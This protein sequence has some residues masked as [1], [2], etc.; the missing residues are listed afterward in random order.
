MKFSDKKINHDEAMKL[1]RQDEFVENELTQIQAGILTSSVL[2]P[3]STAY[4]TSSIFTIA[5]EVSEKVLIQALQ[6]FIDEHSIM[7]CSFVRNTLNRYRYIVNNNV[8]IALEKKNVKDILALRESAGLELKNKIDLEK[9]Q[10]FKFVLYDLENGERYLQT[11]IHHIIFDDRSAQVFLSEINRNIK[12]Y[13]NGDIISEPDNDN[14]FREYAYEENRYLKSPK[15]DKDKNYWLSQLRSDLPE[16]RMNGKKMENGSTDIDGTCYYTELPFNLTEKLK[17]KEFGTKVSVYTK[18]LTAYMLLLAEYGS[19]NMISVGTAVTNRTVKN[20]DSVGCFINMAVVREMIA[21]EKSI[22]DLILNVN[23]KTIDALEHERYP[24]VLL[25]RE[26]SKRSKK[27]ISQLFNAAMYYNEWKSSEEKYLNVYEMEEIHQSGEYDLV[28]EI[29]K[30]GNRFE[31][32]FKYDRNKF[33]ASFIKEL[34]DKYRYI[35]ECMVN[36]PE[37]M[38]GSILRGVIK[39]KNEDLSFVEMFRM[40]TK[41]APESIAVS[42]DGNDFTYREIYT[43]SLRL[44]KYLRMK[45]VND[46]TYVGIMLR[47]SEKLLISLIAVQMAGGAYIPMDPLYPKERIR[48]MADAAKLEYII[49]DNDRISDIC[50]I[51]NMILYEEAEKYIRSDLTMTNIDIHEAHTGRVAYVIFTSGSTGNPKGIVIPHSA[52]SNFLIS[53]AELIGVTEKDVIL[54][55]TTI[56]FDIAVLEMYLML[57]VGGKVEIVPDSIVRNGILL[58]D[59]FMSSNFTIMQATPATWQMLL[60]AGWNEKKHIKILCGGEKMT[61]ELADEILKYSDE[62]WNMYGPTETTVWSMVSPVHSS[63]QIILGLPIRKTSIYILDGL[64]ETDEG[65][66]CIG[67]AGLAEGYL[68]NEEATKRQFIYYEKAGERIYRTGDIVKRMPDGNIVYVGRADF[69]IKIKGYRVELGEIEKQL[70][71]IK[72]IKEAVVVQKAKSKR[73]K[74]YLISEGNIR[75]DISTITDRLKNCLAEYMIPSSFEYVEAYPLT[76]NNKV[77]R[78]AMAAEEYVPEESSIVVSAQESVDTAPD[79]DT[80]SAQVRKELRRLTAKIQHLKEEDIKDDVY[81]GEYEYESISFTALCAE[82]NKVYSIKLDPSIFYSYQTIGELSAHIVRD[83]LDFSEFTTDRPVAERQIDVSEK[84]TLSDPRTESSVSHD[85]KDVAVIG[86]GGILPGADDPEQFWDILINEKDMITEI[87]ISRWDWREYY[88]RSE[89]DPNRISSKWGG[90]INDPDKF[91]AEFFKISPVEAELMDPQQ[92]I[93]LQLVWETFENAGYNP[94]NLS[95]H[96]VGVFIGATSTDY[97]EISLREAA[98]RPH[99]ITGIAN[100]IISNR[101]SYIYNFMGPSETI[102]TACSS[103]LVSICR[104]VDAINNGECEYAIAGGVNLL[105][106]PFTYIA[107]GNASM[108]SKDGRCKAFDE[109]ANG[110]VRG[111]GAVTLLL[112]PLQKAIEDRDY[113]YAVVKGTAVNH[114]GRSNSLTAPNSNAQSEVIK[115]AHHK[116]N[117]DPSTIGYIET[118]GTG[119]ALGDPIEINGLINAFRDLYKE[120]NINE[121]SHKCKL[122]SVKTNIGHLEAASG[123]ASMLKMVMAINHKTVPANIHFHKLNPYIHLENTPFEIQSTKTLWNNQVFCGKTIPLRGGVSSFGFGGT[124]AHVIL[125]EYLANDRND[126]PVSNNKF[127]IPLSAQYADGLRIY[128]DRL[129]AYIDKFPAEQDTKSLLNRMAYTLQTG[130]EAMRFRKAFV[131]GSLYELKQ[132]LKKYLNEYAPSNISSEHIAEESVFDTSDINFI[133]ER[134]WKNGDLEKITKI[135]ELCMPVEWEKFY[136]DRIEKLPMPT[137]PFRKESFYLNMFSNNKL[138]HDNKPHPLIDEPYFAESMKKGVAFRKSLSY[139]DA[140]IGEHIVKDNYVM[141]GTSYLEMALEG[142]GIIQTPGSVKISGVSWQQQLIFNQESQKDVILKLE[143]NDGKYEYQ[144]VTGNIQPVIHGSGYIEIAKET[145]VGEYIDINGILKRC[146]RKTEKKSFYDRIMQDADIH[147]GSYF[148]GVEEV[149]ANDTEAIGVLGFSERVTREQKFYY[150]H[151]VILDCALQVMGYLIGNEKESDKT[152]IPFSSERIIINGPVSKEKYIVYAK[153]VVDGMHDIYLLDEDGRIDVYIEKLFSREVEDK[154]FLFVPRLKIMQADTSVQS[155]TDRRCAMVYNEDTVDICNNIAER[156]DSLAVMINVDHID[157]IND[158]IIKNKI[159]SIYYISSLTADDKNDLIGTVKN[160]IIGFFRMIKQLQKTGYTL[161][162]CVLTHNIFPWKEQYVLPFHASLYGFCKSAAKEIPQISFRLYDMDDISAGY[163]ERH[164]DRIASHT[165]KSEYVIIREGYWY[166]KK[167]YRY[168]FNKDI[169]NSPAIKQNG[170]YL[171][172]GMGGI[173]KEIG[174]HLSQ[175]Y[176]AT[177]IYVSRGP[178]TVDKEKVMELIRSYGGHAFYYQADLTDA[179]AVKLTID[180]LENDGH[181]INGVIFGTMVLNDMSISAMDEHLLMSV[182]KPKEE[183]ILY[184]WEQ[185]DKTA[186]D[187]ALVMSSVSGIVGNA[188]QSNYSAACAVADSL[189]YAM[190]RGSNVDV[191]VIDWSYWGSVGAVSSDEYNK[192]LKARGLY[193]IHVKEGIRVIEKCLSGGE[194]HISMCK[195]SDDVLEEMGF[196]LDKKIISYCEDIPSLVNEIQ[197]FNS[198]DEENYRIDEG[199]KAIDSYCIRLVLDYFQKNGIF[200]APYETVTFEDTK[201]RLA[202]IDKYVK[203]LRAFLAILIRGG[204]V[205]LINNE[206][207]STDKVTK[208]ST[209]DVIESSYPELSAYSRLTKVCAA[210]FTEILSGKIK[211]TDVMFPGGSKELVSGIYKGNVEADYYNSFVSDWIE[212]YI[213][214]RI[215]MDNNC[216]IRLLEIGAGTG[217]TSLGVFKKISKFSRN[218][219]YI[220]TDISSSFTYYGERTYGEEYPFTEYSVLNIEKDSREYGFDG[221]SFDIVLA[222]NVLH[223]T[224]SIDNTMNNIKLLLRKNGVVLIN[225]LTDFKVFSTVTF[226]LTEGWWL[227]S[228]ELRIPHS[229]LLSVDMWKHRLH[230]C[231]YNNIIVMPGKYERKDAVQHVIVAESDGCFIS[232][233]IRPSA[234]VQKMKPRAADKKVIKAET[235]TNNIRNKKNAPRSMSESSLKELTICWIKEEF[236]SILKTDTGKMNNNSNIGDL[237]IDSLLIIEIHKMWNKVFPQFPSTVLFEYTTINKIADFLIARYESV[238][239]ELIMPEEDDNNEKYEAITETEVF[240]EQVQNDRTLYENETDIDTESRSQESYSS[241]DIAVIGIAGRYPKA[242]NIH[243][244]WKNLKDGV[245]CIRTIPEDRWKWEDYYDPDNANPG[246][247]Y[248]KWGGFIDDVI[249]F[250]A[251]FFGFTEEQA[252]ELD[253]QERILLETTW[254]AL[255]DA[256]YPGRTLS[257]SGKN[258]GV[259]IGTMYEGYNLL[260]VKAWENGIRTEAQAAHWMLPNRIS[261]Y[262]GFTG[263]SVSF[264]TACASSMTALNYACKS[265]KNGDCNMAVVGGINLILHPRQ[266]VRLAHLDNLS[267]TGATMPFSQNANGFVEG[268]GAGT[269]LLKPLKDAVRDNDYIYGVI[270]ATNI[271]CNGGDNNFGNPNIIKQAELIEKSLKQAGFKPEDIN[272]V[273]AHAVGTVLGDSV[274]L[275]ALNKVFSKKRNKA[276]RCPVGTVKSNI[277]HTEA[278]SGIAALTKVLLQMKYK[279]LV[280]SINCEPINEMLPL[281]ESVFYIN[282]TLTDWDTETENGRRK[283]RRACI[284]S[285]GAGGSNANMIIEEYDMKQRTTLDDRK[286]VIVLSAKNSESLKKYASVLKDYLIN[287]NVS[288][289]DIAYTLQAGREAMEFRAAFVAS[290]IEECITK[291]KSIVYAE[292]NEIYYG[293]DV[294]TEDDKFSTYG[295]SCDRIAEKWANGS[296]IDWKQY[297]EEND[298]KRIP[299]PTYQFRRKNY[300]LDEVSMEMNVNDYYDTE[301]Y[302][303]REPFISEH[304]SYG[305]AT[306]I[307]MTYLSLADRALSQKNSI[308][309]LRK[310]LFLEPLSVDEKAKTLIR[311]EHTKSGDILFTAE[312][313]GKKQNVASAVITECSE[314]NMSKKQIPSFVDY[315]MIDGESL[316]RMK[317]GIYGSSFHTIERVYIKDNDIWARLKLNPKMCSDTHYYRIHPVL[318]DAAVL[319]RMVEKITTASDRYIPFMIKEFYGIDKLDDHCYCHITRSI[320]KDDIWEGD[321]ELISE[322]TNNVCVYMNG[323]VCKKK[324]EETAATANKT[325]VSGTQTSEHKSVVVNGKNGSIIDYIADKISG[326]TGVTIRENDLNMNF[327]TLGC[328]SKGIIALNQMIQND[329]GIDLYPTVFFEYT[330]IK[331]LSEYLMKE[332]P[333]K[334]EKLTN[335]N[336]TDAYEEIHTT[337]SEKATTAVRV[338]KTNSTDKDDIAIIGI[339]GMFPGAK[340]IEEYWQNL[341][342]NKNSITK[343]PENRWDW[344]EFYK[345]SP[346]ENNKT[347]IIWGGFMNDIDKFDAGF[348]GINP[349]EAR[350][351][352]PQQRLMLQLAWNVIEDAGYNPKK[353]AGSKTGVFIGV[354]DNDYGGLDYD[355]SSTSTAQLLTGT[356]H[357]MLTGRISYFFD[358]HGPS[359][360]V[361][362]ACASSL[363][364]IIHAVEAIN[365]GRCDIALAGGVHIMLDPKI[366]IAFDTL[367]ILSSDGVCRAFDKNA[368]GTVRGEGAGLVMLKRLSKAIEDKD[369]IYAVIKGTGISHGGTSNS[370]TAPNP[371]QQEAAIIDAFERADI[372]PSS[373]TFIET[374]G[375][376]TILGDPI[377]ITSLKNSFRHT[378]E[379]RGESIGNEHTCGL[380]AVKTQ[381]GHLETA[382]GIAGVIKVILSMKHKKLPGLLNFNELNPY[383]ELDNSPF[384]I[385]KDT[386]EWVHIKDKSGKE[387]PYRAGVSAFGFSGVNAHILLEEYIAE[388]EEITSSEEMIPFSARD[389][390]QLKENI[391]KFAEYI[392][393]TPANELPSFASASYT[394]Q[395]GR[396]SMKERLAVIAH[397]FNE[398]L[399][400]LEKYRN[401]DLTD[402][403]LYCM[404]N[405]TGRSTSTI[406]EKAT[407][408]WVTTS[409]MDKSLI[410]KE[411]FKV[412]LP[413]YQF[414]KKRYWLDGKTKLNNEQFSERTEAHEMAAGGYTEKKQLD[415]EIFFIRDHVVSGKNILPGVVYIELARQAG[416]KVA[417]GKIISGMNNIIWAKAM[418]I[419]KNHPQN[420][421]LDIRPDNDS[422]VYEIRTPEKGLHVQGKLKFAERM[423][424]PEKKLSFSELR[425]KCFGKIESTEMYQLFEMAGFTY[426]KTFKPVQSIF[427]SETEAVGYIKTDVSLWDDFGRYYLHPV[428]LEGSLQVA[429]YLANRTTDPSVPYVPYSID[430]LIIYAP[431]TKECFVHAELKDYVSGKNNQKVDVKVCDMTGSVLVEIKGY[432]VR[433]FVKNTPEKTTNQKGQSKNTEE[434]SVPEVNTVKSDSETE[435][436]KQVLSAIVDI[437]AEITEISPEEVDPDREL[438]DYNMDSM[439]LMEFANKINGRFRTNLTPAHFFEIEPLTANNSAEYICMNYAEQIRSMIGESQAKKYQAAIFSEKVAAEEKTN[440]KH[441]E[442]IAIIGMAGRMPMSDDCEEFWN[443]LKANRDMITDIPEAR[444]D[445]HKYYGDPFKEKNKTNSHWGGFMNDIDKFD[446]ELFGITPKEARYM[447]PQQRILFELIWEMLEDAG[448]TK[449]QVSGTK[450]GVYIGSSNSDY[451]T[452]AQADVVDSLTMTGNC[453]PLMVNKISYFFNFTG[454]SEVVD[455]LCS[456][457]LVAI[458]RAI[459][460]IRNGICDVAVAGGVNV[461]LSPDLYISYGNANMLS[462]DGKCKTF[463]KAADGFVRAEGAGVIYLK[464]LSK[465]IED[466]DHIYAVIRGSAVNHG[467]HTKSLTAPNPKAQAEVI[468]AAL[469]NAGVDFSTINYLELHGTGT[470]LGDPIEINGLRMVYEGK[471]NKD[472]EAVMKK[473]FLGAVKTNAGHLESAAGIAGV[474]KIILAMKHKL[475]PANINFN[476]L[477]PYIDLKETPF[478]LLNKNEYWEQVEDKSGRKL[479]RR[480]GISSFGAGG[481]NAHIIFEEYDR[482]ENSSSE[483]KDTSKVEIPI[484]VLSANNKESLKLYV[485]K[486]IHFINNS[487]NELKDIAF[488][489]L[490]LKEPLH[491]RLAIKAETKSELTE[492]LESYLNEKFYSGL[493]TKQTIKDN[494]PLLNDE[495]CRKWVCGGKTDWYLLYNAE[496]YKRIRL[497]VYPFQKTSYWVTDVDFDNKTPKAVTEYFA[498]VEEWSK[499]SICTDPNKYSGRTIFILTG[500]HSF[501][502]AFEDSVHGAHIVTID[503]NNY[504]EQFIKE[505]ENGSTP[506]AVIYAFPLENDYDMEETVYDVSELI[507]VL[508]IT[509]GNHETEFI[510]IYPLVSDIRQVYFRAMSGFFRSIAE[511]YAYYKT[512]IIQ[513]ELYSAVEC[514]INELLSDAEKRFI[515]VKYDNSRYENVLFEAIP[516]KSDKVCFKENGVY[517]ITGGSGKIAG[518]LTKYLVKEYNA[519]V[520]LIGRR[521]IHGGPTEVT[522]ELN[523]KAEKVSYLAIDV[524][525]ADDMK[526]LH[527]ELDRKYGKLNGVFHLAGKVNDAFNFR[528]NS[529]KMRSVIDPKLKGAILLDDITKDYD[530]DFFIMFSSISAVIGNAGQSDYSYANRFL[531]IFAQMREQYVQNGLRSGRSCSINWPLWKNGGMQPAVSVFTGISDAVGLGFIS[532][533]VNHTNM[534]LFSGDKQKIS[535]IAGIRKKLETEKN[536]SDS[537]I[538]EMNKNK[539]D[540]TV[541]VPSYNEQALRIQVKEMIRKYASEVSELQKEKIED[542]VDFSDYGMDSIMLLRLGDAL[543]PLAGSLPNDIFFEY[544]NIS[545]LTDYLMKEYTEELR[546]SLIPSDDVRLENIYSDEAEENMN[547]KIT[548]D[549]AIIGISGRYSAADNAEEFWHKISSGDYSMLD[550][551]S[552]ETQDECFNPEMFELDHKDTDHLSS[553]YKIMMEEIWR[554]Y[555][556]AG[557]CT[558]ELVDNTGM[559]IGTSKES[560]VVNEENLYLADHLL[561]SYGLCGTAKTIISENDAS[562]EAVIQACLSL[563]KGENKMAFAGAAMLASCRDKNCCEGAGIVLLKRLTDAIADN[564]IIYAVIRSEDAYNEISF[565]EAENMNAVPKRL[566]N[567]VGKKIPVNQLNKLTGDLGTVTGI[568]ELTKTVMQI[569]NRPSILESV[570]LQSEQETIDDNNT[571]G[572]PGDSCNRSKNR[573]RPECTL[574]CSLNDRHNIKAILIQEWLN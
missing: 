80:L 15:A 145:P 69:Q 157:Q 452:L 120:W 125:E 153:T 67:G 92:R 45:G 444:F 138:Y 429:G 262:F 500:N 319:C 543:K 305:K 573:S 341:I 141:P 556:S 420:I 1:L 297:N 146:V 237:G 257:N 8:N 148:Q 468:E 418:E 371:A 396:E 66:L 492:A 331:A 497:P 210:N 380:G 524:T 123:T 352:D 406:I 16:F 381:I 369:N 196:E 471:V 392:R 310:I 448:Y 93:I 393:N 188:G 562:L 336:N 4:N 242:D 527:D 30:K 430:Q 55:E 354:A 104:A 365:N 358:F 225:E 377:E 467:G 445:W 504:K 372:S 235:V 86:I 118:H 278:A 211:E 195:A 466:K 332:Y 151:P 60:A 2:Y 436:N 58:L 546:S 232:S 496:N 479:P 423:P 220:Y 11:I 23:A 457:S 397:D 435:V 346:D 25:K 259:F 226:G 62:L 61:R 174:K 572:V 32:I 379:K 261:H 178:M 111:E 487:D 7:R 532:T 35:I 253:P 240:F 314:T 279:Q 46:E 133:L 368:N 233:E 250:D 82:L 388:K 385:I 276:R 42:F 224:K 534:I 74:A 181:V 84:N 147:Y 163:I 366:Y 256:G 476:I 216:M 51:N 292:E 531:D 296:V 456:S 333:D 328:D 552:F 170:T 136:K 236:S 419:E 400:V 514:C 290:D 301:V 459:W 509:Y 565:I 168:K 113:I 199:F 533:A 78:K 268:E 304:L 19:S 68:N 364:A 63:G 323:V 180:K 308:T 194:N 129:L 569:K 100:S 91:D 270:K 230:E 320:S 144:I 213:S 204:Y 454:P 559:F 482:N 480:A 205:E 424:M 134:C 315:N 283:L 499:C 337:G 52:L 116:A 48:Y 570:S 142:V 130:R 166:E 318:L 197:I 560:T 186:L 345:N 179:K 550:S 555:E 229:P 464:P 112:K 478:C 409:V 437:I 523:D 269:V 522:G 266:H 431:L 511:E 21:P 517:L 428:M 284:D 102:D 206:Y 566:L 114:C 189:A 241:D 24:Y 481:V 351:M 27:L 502:D 37:V 90:F 490:T 173:S 98:I 449:S 176:N 137:Y 357:N 361:D 57:T 272:Y 376:G 65:E 201:K 521:I 164:I 447:D 311:L 72:G 334:C 563:Q 348:F 494:A 275:A 6:R 458:N 547:K 73:L 489:S 122:G 31:A 360:P 370:M 561:K 119:T 172:T 425:E 303:G 3:E 349:R 5:P 548:D 312:S 544:K 294:E 567:D 551:V 108:L 212:E 286:Q 281:N 124:N 571:I 505:K 121:S 412:S 313:G 155:L 28:L 485:R 246:K 217:G 183:G 79:T 401:G 117:V 44:A 282:K 38:V 350:H 407:L 510:Y 26:I 387:L 373:V 298:C 152:K 193:P 184:L 249:G 539:S 160:G 475:I 330:S 280:P 442:P 462:S 49:T 538:V 394:L 106:S 508:N 132:S 115:K 14:G 265:I 359:E 87:P 512:K 128:A 338:K 264:D 367:G 110:Y 378:S 167:W 83:C 169:H 403:R 94:R 347:K 477:N 340:D 473:C 56:C 486:M 300:K 322:T 469:D 109:K 156:I 408:D 131:A 440:I 472:S 289:N 402:N 34:A 143:E 43:S 17:N 353:L 22:K 105:L 506:D 549:I 515:D 258:V 525:K 382:A 254:S 417:S 507:R 344:R 427:Y 389:Q 395:T 234:S 200:T 165:G 520:I 175:E 501:A 277:G 227:F 553:E 488:S 355:E 231:G 513:A 390:H 263:P 274:E 260:A 192:K 321:L 223:A 139:R 453:Q 493:Y 324:S 18:F 285:N 545:E 495:Q 542:D 446:A 75:T 251:E 470:P 528:N 422:M 374:H 329:L 89:D 326:Y 463:D 302:Y 439:L 568:A 47:R 438:E 295:V 248:S 455:T 574:I 384:Y 96:D 411:H 203:L 177:I 39:A 222:T 362:N 159:E 219:Q 526:K 103:G 404:E 491:E 414:E 149:Y 434:N 59:K 252:K 519:N 70:L 41:K 243:E 375:T 291:L 99:T 161:D 273:E 383:I 564:D 450:T 20:I 40:Q 363:V 433:S 85:D 557:Y 64:N 316:Y 327:M 238:L 29:L 185:L 12:M 13:L 101:V 516:E 208:N 271:N 36:Y 309:A 97:M 244:F 107:L 325:I 158:Y 484:F 187:F 171:L 540:K 10:L 33:D 162:V 215:S 190:K 255:E 391:R 441:N 518:I 356:A 503:T 306:L 541:S 50:D 267:H 386:Q 537:E 9:D 299:L 198:P 191:K 335:N 287:E 88:Y 529:G 71:K 530:L 221:N 126:S 398:L 451:R 81:F 202:V 207:R 339:S 421:I 245:D 53:M 288:L 239:R 293:S 317:S 399:T 140:V 426:G 410:L 535:E 307:G 461:I 554:T 416:S 209:V 154:G 558:N 228:D 443:N 460:D 76:C 474:L 150:A 343:I 218:I 247:G 483:M 413:G 465:A 536:S 127:I 135:W 415:P 95:G 77:D 405:I 342:S 182:I 214:K 432:L 498:C 54:A